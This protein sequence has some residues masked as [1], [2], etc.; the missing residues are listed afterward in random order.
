MAATRGVGGC[1]RGD[2]RDVPSTMLWYPHSMS[3]SAGTRPLRDCVRIRLSGCGVA[4]RNQP[5]YGRGTFSR[6]QH[7]RLSAFQ[8]SHNHP[9]LGA[10]LTHRSSP[11]SHARSHVASGGLRWPCG[12]RWLR[13]WSIRPCSSYFRNG[14]TMPHGHGRRDQDG[15]H[16][17]MYRHVNHRDDGRSARISCNSHTSI[18]AEQYEPMRSSLSYIVT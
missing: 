11:C 17:Q 13:R 7:G 4:T 15:R 9:P 10:V 6:G 8:C 3:S 16:K 14:T 18:T 2:L 12:M 5:L 1:L